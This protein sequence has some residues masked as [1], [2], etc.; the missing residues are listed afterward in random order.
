[1]SCS[2]VQKSPTLACLMFYQKSCSRL[3]DHINSEKYKTRANTYAIPTM[4]LFRVLTLLLEKAHLS[5]SK[6]RRTQHRRTQRT[7][8]RRNVI[9]VGL[10]RCLPYHMYLILLLMS[11]LRLQSCGFFIISHAVHSVTLDRIR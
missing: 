5:P 9:K 7:S 1:M 10:S 2:S 6:H 3:N 8:Y 11:H 4:L